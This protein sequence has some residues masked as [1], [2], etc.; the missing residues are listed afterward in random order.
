MRALAMKQPSS[1]P[2]SDQLWK[3]AQ[4]R[5]KKH[6]EKTG[7]PFHLWLLHSQKVLPFPKKITTD[8]ATDL[9]RAFREE[10]LS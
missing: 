9:H 4:S 2:S 5:A 3:Q 8:P 1:P 7:I 10:L 6:A